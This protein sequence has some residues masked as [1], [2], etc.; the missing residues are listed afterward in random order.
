MRNL[1]TRIEAASYLGCS[2]QTITNLVAKGL[3]G[4]YNDTKSRRFYVNA[5]DVKKYAERYK[6]ISVGEGALRAKQAELKRKENDVDEQLKK[7]IED[8]LSISNLRESGLGDALFM[9]YESGH[10]A[11]SPKAHVLQEILHGR[12]IP[13]IAEEMNLTRERVRQMA[14][15]AF[16]GLKGSIQN[17]LALSKK[18]EALNKRANEMETKLFTCLGMQCGGKEVEPVPMVL[19]HKCT[20]YNL[21]VRARN[22]LEIMGIKTI[23]Q[24]VSRK[25]EDLMMCRNMGRKSFMELDVL[26][27]KLGLSWGMEVTKAYNIGSILYDESGYMNDLINNSINDII[28]NVAEK[29][30]LPQEDATNVATKS[31]RE[32]LAV[33]DKK[34]SAWSA[35]RPFFTKAER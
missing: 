7:V 28:N 22:C 17:I 10:P 9:I 32:Y 12:T 33:P 31:I 24:L 6:V 1:M 5:D 19:N 27:N 16:W 18:N 21:S 34:G 15:N 2:D 23:G 3:L 8:S 25:Q 11:D 26:I 13:E 14:T 4:G 35:S 20:S 29:F 30:G